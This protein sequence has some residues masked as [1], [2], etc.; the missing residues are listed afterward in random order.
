MEKRRSP[1]IQ[2]SIKEIGDKDFRVRILGTIVDKDDDKN[3]AILDDGTGKIVIFLPSNSNIK[4]GKLVRVIGKIV[5]REKP[6]MEVEIIQDM[7]KLN[8]RIYEQVNYI[9]EKLR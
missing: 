7:S 8:L 4:E 1:S 3:S 9:C 2:R 6:E 5:R